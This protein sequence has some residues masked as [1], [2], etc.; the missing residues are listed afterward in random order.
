M[1]EKLKEFEIKYQEVLKEL[2]VPSVFSDQK[3]VAE[4]G[5]KEAYLKN[6]PKYIIRILIY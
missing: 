3:K 6:T 1:I 2:S 4:L 5:K